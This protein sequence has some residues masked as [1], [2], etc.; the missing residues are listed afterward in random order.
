MATDLRLATVAALKTDL[1]IKA[2]DTANDDLLGDLLDRASRVIET[3]VDRRLVYRGSAQ[4]EYHTFE[5]RRSKFFLLDRP[6]LSS[7]S[8]IITES[9]SY[10]HASATALTEGDEYVVDTDTGRVTRMSSG[11]PIWWLTGV[12]VV[13]ATYA[14]GYEDDAN[15]KANVPADL[16]D[17]ALSLA[18]IR[19]REIQE[20]LQGV[21][22]RVDA[23]GA[24]IR[25]LSRGLT[26][27]HLTEDHRMQLSDFYNR[28]IPTGVRE[29]A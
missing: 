13:K 2:G 20:K 19:F 1:S 27:A 23:S 15:D 9:S 25:Q 6:V 28:T 7:P 21:S 12:R 17:V 29:A 5:E 14:A 10:D 8:I 24:Q 22:Q 26:H 18:A 3:E 11:Q 16:Q 4:I